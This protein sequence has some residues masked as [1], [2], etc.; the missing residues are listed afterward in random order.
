MAQ[1]WNRQLQNIN[2]LMSEYTKQLGPKLQGFTLGESG[3]LKK[4]ANF[5]LG[6]SG[7]LRTG[8]TSPVVLKQLPD[9]IRDNITKQGIKPGGIKGLGGPIGS[10]LMLLPS[11]YG[12][13][14]Y[15]NLGPGAAALQQTPWGQLL[16]GKPKMQQEYIDG[17]ES[18]KDFL[19]NIINK[20]DDNKSSA[21]KDSMPPLEVL[22]DNQLTR[23]IDIQATEQLPTLSPQLVAQSNA[24][25]PQSSDTVGVPQSNLQAINDY[26]QQLKDINQPYV[27][28]LQNYYNKYPNMLDQ[29]QR[30][31]RFWQ[32]VSSLT[33][34]NNWAKMA[35]YYNP[36]TNEANKI[37]TIKTLQDA[38]ASNVNAINEIIGNLAMAQ[39]MGLSPEAA[40]ANK[41]LLTMMA[42]KD[43]ENNKYRI[44]LENNLMKKYGIDRNY[45]KALAVQ[46]M[47]G[48]NALDVA[49]IYMGGGVAPG[50]N[51]QGTPANNQDVGLQQ[52]LQNAQKQNNR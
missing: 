35:N 9:I 11:M 25:V 44:A 47:R 39:E 17:L 34:N 2:R 46:A 5:Q 30:A 13:D 49:N 1:G 45:A 52:I 42:A 4:P 41:N 10:A 18:T 14:Q 51:M 8:K 29:A 43:R 7:P 40:F 32:G 26:I 28:A 21:Q 15:G 23:G 12:K 27:E 24:V 31:A 6:Q 38:Q 37:N 3:Q 22:D 33:G 19:N 16:Y 48:Q 36:I 50:L 20:S